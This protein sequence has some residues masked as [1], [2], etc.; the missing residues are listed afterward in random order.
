MAI[1]IEIWQETKKEY[2]G[3]IQ[4]TRDLT[5][6]NPLNMQ[7]NNNILFWNVNIRSSSLCFTWTKST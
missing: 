6:T 1:I 3:E 2:Y 4:D 5:S 7:K